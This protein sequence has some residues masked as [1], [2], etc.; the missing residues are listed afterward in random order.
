MR[1]RKIKTRY[2]K[3][4]PS[5]LATKILYP[6]STKVVNIRRNYNADNLVDVFKNDEE[7][8]EYEETEENEAEGTIFRS[9]QDT[10][11]DTAAALQDLLHGT[12][13]RW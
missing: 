1:D 9:S 11:D 13:I 12:Y 4:P 7:N 6:T 8:E 3:K 2:S 10:N 5:R